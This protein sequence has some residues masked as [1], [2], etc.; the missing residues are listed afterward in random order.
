MANYISKPLSE[1]YHSV[2]LRL[3]LVSFPNLTK[4]NDFEPSWRSRNHDDSRAIFNLKGQF[5]GFIIASY[6]RATGGSMYIDYIALDPSVRGQGIGSHLL[7]EIVKTI[8]DKRGSVHLYP[9]SAD[10]VGFYARC[11]FVP[12][13]DGY[14]VVHSYSTRSRL[15]IQ[16]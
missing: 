9:E 16:I 11:G 1:E 2:S 12:T 5:I 15:A 7:K 10:R 14:Y 4:E 13:H 6:N 8:L 3:F